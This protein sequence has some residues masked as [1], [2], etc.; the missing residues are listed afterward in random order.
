MNKEGHAVYL[1]IERFRVHSY[2][3]F[4]F[5]HYGVEFADRVTLAALDAGRLI[6]HMGLSL[7]SGNAVDRAAPGAEAAADA[8]VRQYGEMDELL[9]LA[10]RTDVIVDMGHVFGFKRCAAPAEPPPKNNTHSECIDQTAP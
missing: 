7:F 8:L 10:R 3:P 9:A 5:A 6:Y 1:Y 4:L 2:T